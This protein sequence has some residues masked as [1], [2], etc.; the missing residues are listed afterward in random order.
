MK[1]EM[2]GRFWNRYIVVHCLF[3]QREDHRARECEKA[4]FKRGSCCYTCGLPQEAYRK[5]IHGDVRTGECEIGLRDVIRG[6]CWAL[7]GS[8]KCLQSWL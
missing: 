3:C 7:Y 4:K 5:D 6:W 1:N 8:E 2:E